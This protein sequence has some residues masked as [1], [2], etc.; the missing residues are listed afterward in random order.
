M[1]FFRYPAPSATSA[2]PLKCFKFLAAKIESTT[3]GSQAG[4]ETPQTQLNKF[5]IDMQEP[6]QHPDS[7]CTSLLA[8]TPCHIMTVSL[9]LP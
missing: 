1:A 4:C 3:T 7:R 2:L 5:I 6:G 8:W 9:T